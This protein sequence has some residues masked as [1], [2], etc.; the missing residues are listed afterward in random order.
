[1]VVGATGE[2]VGANGRL[3]EPLKGDVY[4]TVSARKALDLMNA[5]PG[6]S[7]RAGIGGCATSVPLDGDGQQEQCAPGAKPSGDTVTVDDAVFG[8][9]SHSVDGR[10][11][12]VPSWLFE[13][14]P[15][16]AGEA[17]TVTYPAV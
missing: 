11:A 9:A 3:A 6:E 7:P 2:V 14:R 17:L 5:A 4:P 15:E 12:L 13:V 16:G 1:V 10:P 8:L